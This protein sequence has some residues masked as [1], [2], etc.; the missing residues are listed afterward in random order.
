MCELSVIDELRSI[1]SEVPLLL[2][3]SSYEGSQKSLSLIAKVRIHTF[4]LGRYTIV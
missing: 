4:A 1:A 2:G 3:P